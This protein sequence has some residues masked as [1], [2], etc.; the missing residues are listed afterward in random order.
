MKQ[1]TEPLFFVPNP[2]CSKGLMPA[3]LATF[4][5]WWDGPSYLASDPITKPVQPMLNPEAVT[6]LRPAVACH[7]KVFLEGRFS[8]FH[9]TLK[10]TAWCMRFTN[11]LKAHLNQSEPIST[12][13]LN[14]NEL[15]A[16]EYVLYKKSQA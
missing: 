16:A 12:N 11:N 15:R 2:L 10:I 6:E 8:N 3:D 4:D 13:H 14:L 1:N 9:H 5:L 7:F